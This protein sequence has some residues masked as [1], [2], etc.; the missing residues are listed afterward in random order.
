MPVYHFVLK[1]ITLPEQQ[2]I[3]LQEYK[4][5]GTPEIE[6]PG[7]LLAMKWYEPILASA[8]L[9]SLIYMLWTLK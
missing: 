6:N 3:A 7:S 5:N 9:G 4:L 8:V 2:L 1:Q